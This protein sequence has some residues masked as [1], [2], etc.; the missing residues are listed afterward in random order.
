V[1]QVFIK[2]IIWA[3]KLDPELYKSVEA[4]K[5]SMG[6]AMLVVVMVSVMAGIGSIGILG[7]GVMSGRY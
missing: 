2:R 1:S 6:Q 3:L 7:I 4:D 5:G